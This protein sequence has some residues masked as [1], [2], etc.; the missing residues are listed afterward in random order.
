[1]SSPP[2]MSTSSLPDCILLTADAYLVQHRNITTASTTTSNHD[3]IEVSLCPARPPFP[4]KLYVHCPDLTLTG[5]VPR[6]I[7]AVEDL[8]LL[9]VVSV[10]EPLR[11]SPLVIPKRCGRI[12]YHE[13]ST[14]ISIGGEAGSL[15]LWG[16]VDLWHG[17]LFCD[18]LRDAPTLRAVPV[19]VPLDLVSCDNGL[20][21]ELGNP[22]SFRSIA[23]VKG[24]GDNPEGCLKLV[25]LVGNAIY[26]M[27][28]WTIITYTITAMTSHWKDWHND[29]WMQASDITI[30]DQIKSEL[31]QYGLLGSA[32]DQALHNLLVS[33]PAPDISTAA[34]NEGIVYL[35]A[36]NDYHLSKGCM[37]ALDTRKN[38]LIGTAE[39]GVERLPS[40][41]TMY[42]T[43]D[44]C[45]YIKPSRGDKRRMLGLLKPE[46]KYVTFCPELSESFRWISLG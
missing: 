17:I 16:W 2:A 11:K 19:P 5:G 33:H 37:L 24:G 18:V 3:K 23:F 46:S 25:H 43:S 32:S 13:T 35:M 29:C 42:C 15:G 31:L 28:D 4:S 44:I 45:K 14:V 26:K 9:R 20:R 6:V 40:A 34:D 41:L 7:R 12:L 39:F 8:F 30:D 10:T 38:T 21:T 1:M 27:H 22:I 36:R